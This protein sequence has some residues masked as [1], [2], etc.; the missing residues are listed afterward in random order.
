MDNGRWIKPFYY[1]EDDMAQHLASGSYYQDSYFASD[2][3]ETEIC[4][5]KPNEK[6]ERWLD[7]D[8]YQLYHES[9]EWLGYDQD[10]VAYSGCSVF[11]SKK[12]YL[13]SEGGRLWDA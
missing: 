1:D 7:N 3:V 12:Y 6:I 8:Q 4:S 11:L 5:D 10:E 13:G 2:I 9:L